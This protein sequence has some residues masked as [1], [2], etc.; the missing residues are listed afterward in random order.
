MAGAN[1]TTD[2]RAIPERHALVPGRF[3]TRII[4]DMFQAYKRVL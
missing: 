2:A 3:L 4:P 1:S